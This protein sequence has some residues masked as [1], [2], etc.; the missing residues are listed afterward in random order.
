MGKQNSR[1][2]VSKIARCFIA[3]FIILLILLPTVLMFAQGIRYAKP[4]DLQVLAFLGG[5]VLVLGMLGVALLIARRMNL[6]VW[7]ADE[8]RSAPAFRVGRLVFAVLCGLVFLVGGAY[9]AFDGSHQQTSE[10]SQ[11]RDLPELDARGVAA[12]PSDTL[13][14]VTGILDGNAPVSPEDYVVYIQ[15]EWLVFPCENVDCTTGYWKEV[16][17]TVPS[18]TLFVSDS[19]VSTLPVSQVTFGGNLSES[20]D[21]RINQSPLLMA[22]YSGQRLPDGSLR[23]RGLRDGDLVTVVGR[24]AVTGEVI[25][26]HLIGGGHAQLVAH[27]S[28]VSRAAVW[29]RLSGVILMIISPFVTIFIWRELE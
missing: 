17:Q 4:A 27:F 12:T 10:W 13:L 9:Q 20:L 18:L 19:K 8:S 16:A 1:Y 28:T 21:P 6:P 14:A 23:T 5:V 26:V 24:K 11:I 2:V 7:L 22:D 25:P 29:V 3:G 15:E